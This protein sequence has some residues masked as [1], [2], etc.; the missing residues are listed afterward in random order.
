MAQLREQY[1]PQNRQDLKNEARAIFESLNRNGREST[2]AFA[3]FKEVSLVNR[4]IAKPDVELALLF[5]DMTD[6]STKTSS[7]TASSIATILDKYYKDVLPIIYKYNGEV[8]KIIGDGIIAI[9]GYPFTTG[10]VKELFNKA[11]QCASEIIDIRK[12]TTYPVK[13]AVHFGKMIYYHNK[14]T[15]VDEFYAIGKPMTELFRLES[16]SKDCCINFF[17]NSHYDFHRKYFTSVLSPLWR[18]KAVRKVTLKGVHYDTIV[19]LGK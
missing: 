19:E 11:E 3:A 13:V 9:F 1:A 14:N 2:K 6:F 5:I 15:S 8:E 7:L 17:R 16:E 10:S 18:E 12:I 4:L